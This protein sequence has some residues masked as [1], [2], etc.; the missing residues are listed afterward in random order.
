MSSEKKVRTQ[1]RIIKIESVIS[2]RQTSL[3]LILENIHDPHNVSAIMR[4]CDAVG[5]DTV[6]LLYY[7]EKF[8]KIGKK[9]SSSAWKWVNRE[10]FTSVDNCF[11]V[12]KREGFRIYSSWIGEGAVDFYDLDLTGKVA[13]VVGNEHRGI[14][15]EVV[16]KSDKLFY[17][18]MVGMVQ[19]LNVSVATAI[20]LYEA[21]RQR[22][23]K[24]MYDTCMI[25][26]EELDEQIAAWLEK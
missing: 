6:S 14:S 1:K 22:L 8:P 23:G 16:K 19:S 17:I 26:K 9:S 20:I 12:L 24:G 4:T 21:M 10:K 15:E 11:E 13:L 2:K 18:P 7:I 25:T 5:V 3:R